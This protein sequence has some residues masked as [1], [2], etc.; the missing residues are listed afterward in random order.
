MCDISYTVYNRFFKTDDAMKCLLWGFFCGFSQ[1]ENVKYKHVVFCLSKEVLTKHCESR[2]TYC[3]QN[4]SC[5]CLK[6]FDQI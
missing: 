6:L 2:N 3:E 1:A 5:A 4:D